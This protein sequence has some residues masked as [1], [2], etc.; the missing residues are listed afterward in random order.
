M[1][2][3]KFFLES[4]KNQNQN[5]QTNKNVHRIQEKMFQCLAAKNLIKVR[6][7]DT[8]SIYLFF[9]LSDLKMFVKHKKMLLL[10]LCNID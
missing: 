2:I 3:L 6:V 7:L 10:S 8:L 4:L 1:M 9:V 5:K